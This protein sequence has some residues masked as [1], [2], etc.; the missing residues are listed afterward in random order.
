[1]IRHIV[2]IQFNP[3]TSAADRADLVDRLRGMPAK[4]DVIKHLEVGVN[5]TDSPRARDLAL[6]VDFADRAG[7]AAYATHPDHEA[8]K[9]IIAER[10]GPSVV[11][12]YE[13]D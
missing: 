13:I 10:C 11:V 4:I 3:E 7:L 5:F 9:A 2:F 1:M 8:V 6:I 12:D